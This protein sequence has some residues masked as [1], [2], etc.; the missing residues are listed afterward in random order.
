MTC[1]NATPVIIILSPEMRGYLCECV[2]SAISRM[3]GIGTWPSRDNNPRLYACARKAESKTLISN[4]NSVFLC[5]FVF[6]DFRFS[7]VTARSFINSKNYVNCV[8]VCLWFLFL[9]SRDWFACLLV[10]IVTFIIYK[11]VLWAVFVGV[12]KCL[13][14]SFNCLNIDYIGFCFRL[15]TNKYKL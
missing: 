10:W 8:C 13:F 7:F 14:V 1:S 5:L 2:H 4:D 15:K 9:A 11:C 12:E 3:C 6:K